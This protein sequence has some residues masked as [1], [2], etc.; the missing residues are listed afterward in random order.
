MIAGK[1][2]RGARRRASMR[3]VVALPLSEVIVKCSTGR[4]SGSVR[5]KLRWNEWTDGPVGTA[6]FTSAGVMAPNHA[7]RPEAV[8]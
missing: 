1:D 2:S 7:P 4:D 3:R 6:I 5:D 8:R